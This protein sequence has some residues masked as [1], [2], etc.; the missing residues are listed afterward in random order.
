M[1]T[2]ACCNSAVWQPDNLWNVEK[3][4]CVAIPSTSGDTRTR[5]ETRR[6]KTIRHT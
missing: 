4:V 6:K 5:Q 3:L 1:A 2:T